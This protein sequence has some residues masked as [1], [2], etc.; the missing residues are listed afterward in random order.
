MEFIGK[1]FDFADAIF[2]RLC[3]SGNR[4][5]ITTAT[6]LQASI[7]TIYFP[8]HIPSNAFGTADPFLISANLAN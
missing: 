6:A 7:L 3:C 5:R 8:I 1:I 4:R 2:M